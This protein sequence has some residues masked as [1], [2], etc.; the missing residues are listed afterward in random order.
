MK[1]PLNITW[2]SEFIPLAAVIAS[3]ITSALSYS[4]LPDRV[5][6]HWNFYGEADGWSSRGFHALFF[7]ALLAAMYVLFLILPSID[8]KKD[9]YQ[10]FAG[11]YNI[12]RS[13][14]MLVLFAVYLM[15]T[16]VNLGYDINISQVVPTII[17]L[18]MIVLGNYMS[19][20]KNNWFVGIRTPWTI[21]SDNVWQKTHRLG[22]LMFTFFGFSLILMPYLPYS[23]GMTF[24]I[25]GVIAVT[26]VP[27]LASY[28]FY[29]NEKNK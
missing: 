3:I 29:R 14:I 4:Y 12:F 20:I 9:R 11:V 8:P 27:I 25:I 19:K 6:S 21:S 2:K 10:D 22:G 15:A 28:I 5:I 17:G 16:L 23:A 24:F 1:S 7:P 26:V 18:M 13:A